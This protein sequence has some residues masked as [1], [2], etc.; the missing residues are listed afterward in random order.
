MQQ[1]RLRLRLFGP[2]TALDGTVG[3]DGTVRASGLWKSPSGYPNMTVLH[4]H[5]ADGVMTGT[6]SDFR[7]VTDLKLR[8]IGRR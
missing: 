7:C 3:A 4:G 2:Q 5:V 1:G 8:R 6:A